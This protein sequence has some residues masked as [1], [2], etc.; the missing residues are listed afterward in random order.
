M[1]G[2]GRF[3]MVWPTRQPHDLSG[4]RFGRL[5]ALS[6]ADYRLGKSVIWICLCDC[7]N[8][9]DV[10]AACLKNKSAKSCG[11]LFKECLPPV[12]YTHR[13]YGHPSFKV[14]EGM[15]SRC[16]NPKN[17]DFAL[18]GGRGINVCERW[19]DPKNFAEDMGEKPPGH[20]LDRIDSNGNYCP[21]NCRWATTMEQGANK[22]TNR[23]IELNGET[24]HLTEWCRRLNVKPS[25]VLNRIHRGIDEAT[26]LTMPAQRKRK[27]T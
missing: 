16:K 21:E 22:R 26:A 11:C 12:R 7:G 19:T 2:V 5:T 18:Y 14:W 9:K 6:I 3:D 1:V 27:V 13:M 24:L 25:T 15:I 20:S 23:M 4:Q 8:Q 10:R 17:K